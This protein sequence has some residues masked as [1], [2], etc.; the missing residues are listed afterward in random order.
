MSIE[1]F[2]HVSRAHLTQIQVNEWSQL[3]IPTN[4][5]SC[6]SG[7]T[8]CGNSYEG[9]RI[10]SSVSFLF[11]PS[12]VHDSETHSPVARSDL[13]RSDFTHLFKYQKEFARLKRMGVDNML[14]DFGME[15]Q[16]TIERAQYLPPEFFLALSRYNMGLVFST[17]RIPSG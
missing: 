12:F 7:A 3:R 6:R 4:S 5:D 15:G 14:L 8:L 1:R 10:G 17:V 11:L 16:Q 2:M 13:V 9:V